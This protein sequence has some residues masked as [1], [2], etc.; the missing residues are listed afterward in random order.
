MNNF[1]LQNVVKEATRFDHRSGRAT[2]LDPILIS[3]DCCATFT[4][5]IDINRQ[6]S[7]HN[8]TKVYLRIRILAKF[9]TRTI[10][11]YKHADFTRFNNDIQNFDWQT[12][13]TAFG[14]DIDGMAV[15]FTDKY[16]E[17]A[18]NSIPTK[19]VTIRSSDKPWFNSEIRK[20]IRLRDRLHKK[21]RKLRT[22]QNT[23]KFKVQR[24]KVNNMIIHAKEQFYLN[25]NGLLDEKSNKNPKA[26][27]SLVK[28]VMGNCRSTS[29]PPLLNQNTNEISVDEKEKADLLNSYFCNISTSSDDRVIPPDLPLLTQHSLDIDE[30]TEAEIKDILKSLEIGKASGEDCISHQ[31]LK[32]KMENILHTKFR[33]RCSPL[34][35]DLYRVNLVNDPSCECGCPLEDSIH[36]F[37]ECPLYINFRNQLFKNIQHLADISIEHI[38][39]GTDEITVEQNTILFRNVHS[40][41]RHTK[42]FFD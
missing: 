8:A 5:V 35:A 32:Y 41:I 42:R 14:D 9:F 2:L 23:K 24:N 33:H 37:L 1:C 15:F 21:L 4:E 36:V 26:F 28:K 20:E 13:L 31:M 25:A 17:I 30:I 11:L 19:T 16:I 10:W 7:D 38:L 39:F 18:R 34:K 3:E 40:Y 22:V 6:M 27:W 12:T 29:I